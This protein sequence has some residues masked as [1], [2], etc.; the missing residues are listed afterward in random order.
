MSCFQIR[1]ADSESIRRERSKT[2]ACFGGKNQFWL[3]MKRLL[4]TAPDFF[5]ELD[6]FSRNASVSKELEANVRT[7][8]ADIEK[9][10]DEAV[11]DCIARFDGAKLGAEEF[12]IS[13]EKLADALKQ[14]DAEK[15]KGISERIVVV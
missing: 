12:R 1:R 3:D 7:L 4:F 10:G 6:L 5:S 13:G 2:I 9:R 15:E 14:V 11:S 8:I